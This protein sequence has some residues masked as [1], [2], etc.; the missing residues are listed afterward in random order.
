MKFL[1]DLCS[2][3]D[4]IVYQYIEK[5]YWYLLRYS[6]LYPKLD[7]P[8]WKAMS[9][10]QFI[11]MFF[12]LL[13]Q[14]FTIIV[15]AFKL[16]DTQTLLFEMMHYTILMIDLIFLFI[17]LNM[18]RK[19]FA[20]L[21]R[22]MV[23][24]LSEYDCETENYRNKLNEEIKNNKKKLLTLTL[25]SYAGICL[26]VFMVAP[27][28]DSYLS[29]NNDQKEIYNKYGVSMN[30]PAPQWIPFGSD[31][32][33]TFIFALFMQILAG[34]ICAIVFMAAII[35]VLNCSL[36][37]ASEID[38]LIKSIE[39]LPERTL[40]LYRTI[41]GNRNV[42]FS[43][44]RENTDLLNCYNECL[45][46]NVQHHQQIIKM[47]NIFSIVMGPI[48]FVV[49]SMGSLLIGLSAT[50]FVLVSNARYLIQSFN[51]FYAENYPYI[52]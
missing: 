47:F 27:L 40:S 43:K 23:K 41:Y 33:I 7:T 34:G 25:I 21:H 8:V 17:A 44:I 37:I 36:K 32:L 22:Y 6:C 28:M 16:I 18:R 31:T 5:H 20:I 52:R 39:R 19:Y 24:G 49:L 12:Y 46:Q 50:G 51:Q 4:E 30:L 42:D 9:I 38:L 1:E 48:I 3:D 2:E 45:K 10:V 26:F 15:T 29:D 35:I 11:F 13:Y 14:I